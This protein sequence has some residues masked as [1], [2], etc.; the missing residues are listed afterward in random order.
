MAK[1]KA[2]LDSPAPAK[3]TGS[4]RSGGEKAAARTGTKKT[5]TAKSPAKKRTVKTTGA[6]KTA[7]S[8][9][10]QTGTE[11]VKRPAAKKTGNT[12][13]EEQIRAALLA[14]RERLTGTASQLR[15][16]SLSRDDEVNFEEDGSDAFER[17]LALERASTDYQLINQ[18]DEA[19]RALD[20]GTYGQCEM[21]GCKI[22]PARLKA[23]LFAK[24]CLGCQSEM[25]KTIGGFRNPP[26][27]VR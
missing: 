12:K 24:T 25:E 3:K 7:T 23:L 26:R 14:M 9:P 22:E 16:Q 18:I 19:L 27:P 4:A 6:G 17:L 5:T 21:C 20:Q 13:G 1:E 15:D 10:K 2:K 11:T 8:R